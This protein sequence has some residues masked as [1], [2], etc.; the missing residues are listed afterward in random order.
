M[1]KKSF[2]F[3]WTAEDVNKKAVKLPEGR[4]RELQH[5]NSASF[6]TVCSGS[7]QQRQQST[8]ASFIVVWTVFPKLLFNWS[9]YNIG[10]NSNKTPDSEQ[11]NGGN[12]ADNL[13]LLKVNMTYGS[14]FR[15][16][17]RRSWV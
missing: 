4:I 3:R 1:K 10:G 16:E 5:L 7:N 15:S 13:P 17:I 8:F 14:W 12:P 2:P 9:K 6:A 11:S